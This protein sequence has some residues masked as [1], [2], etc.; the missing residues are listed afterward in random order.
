MPTL[1]ASQEMG[2]RFC[3]RTTIG[4]NSAYFVVPNILCHCGERLGSGRS[5]ESVRHKGLKKQTSIHDERPEGCPFALHPFNRLSNRYGS[6]WRGRTSCLCLSIESRR[7]STS[8]SQMITTVTWQEELTMED[9][10]NCD[11]GLAFQEYLHAFVC[12]VNFGESRW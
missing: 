12:V 10:S 5:E 6:Q 7:Q 3:R 4:P 8:M 1:Y 11:S 9:F 2:R